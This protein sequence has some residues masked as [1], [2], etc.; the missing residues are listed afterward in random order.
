MGVSGFF[1]DF[2]LICNLV[3]LGCSPFEAVGPA[4]AAD[5]CSLAVGDGADERVKVLG[6]AGPPPVLLRFLLH[7]TSLAYTYTH[8]NNP[9][10]SYS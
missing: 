7:G 1:T 2:R 3:V 9:G 10:N 4:V 6:A 5:F 8:V